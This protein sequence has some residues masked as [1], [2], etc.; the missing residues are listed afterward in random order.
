M[1]KS[2]RRLCGAGAAL[3][4]SVAGLTG[5]VEA[6]TA[7]Q[8]PFCNYLVCSSNCIDISEQCSNNCMADGYYCEIGACAFG[9]NLNLCDYD[10]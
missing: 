1:R 8:P 9:M 3:L 5:V 7:E 10:T 4:M 6:S 2:T